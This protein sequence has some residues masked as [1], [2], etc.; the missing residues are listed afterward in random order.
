MS[1]LKR[2]CKYFVACHELGLEDTTLNLAVEVKDVQN[3]P[4]D[5]LYEKIYNELGMSYYKQYKE[6]PKYKLIVDSISLI[7]IWQEQPYNMFDW[8]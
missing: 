3:L 2:D 4:A 6:F 7:D 5:K 8:S 1:K